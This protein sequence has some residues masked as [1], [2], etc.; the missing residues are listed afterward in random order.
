MARLRVSAVQGATPTVR[1]W[2]PHSGL[3]LKQ[4]L[5][6]DHQFLGQFE[7]SL[8]YF[9]K[10]IRLS[11][12]DPVLTFWYGGKAIDY[13][14]LKQYDQAIEWARRAIAINPSS[15]LWA[16]RSLIAALALTDHEREAHEAL[17][18][19]LSSVPGGPKT[20]AAWKATGITKEFS[21]PRILEANDRLTDGL[22]KAG[23]PEG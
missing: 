18:R 13:F 7:Q 11:P 14:G 4:H 15:N 17:D 20:I 6:F 21:D 12:D 22:R 19:Y 8:E 1:Y 5:G 2:A 3:S 9:D 16:H 23:L 10:V